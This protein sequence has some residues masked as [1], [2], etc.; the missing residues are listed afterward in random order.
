MKTTLKVLIFGLCMM[1]LT[2]CGVQ[3]GAPDGSS[4]DSP[5]LDSAAPD[6][7]ESAAPTDEAAQTPAETPADEAGGLDQYAGTYQYDYEF[8]TEDQA[9]DHYIVLENMNGALAGWYYGTS[10]DFDNAREGY[11]PGYYVTD[12]RDMVIGDGTISFRIE[13]GEVFSKPVDLQ[14]R[15][16]VDVRLDE[17]PLWEN[18]LRKK[19]NSFTGT[20]ADGEIVLQAEFGERIFTKID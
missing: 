1:F 20:I 4:P 11:S 5:V 19:E 18:N 13:L 2:A 15:S 16:S 3:S 9:E 8:D 17:N 10:D 14:Y 6:N 12:M 7:G